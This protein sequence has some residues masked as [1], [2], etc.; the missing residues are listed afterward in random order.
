MLR[1]SPS[2]RITEKV[3]VPTDEKN[4]GEKM[5]EV[6]CTYMKLIAGLMV[7]V[8]SVFPS[9]SNIVGRA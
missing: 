1:G 9:R 7:M 3:V 2:E 8:K 5:R 4:T 6:P